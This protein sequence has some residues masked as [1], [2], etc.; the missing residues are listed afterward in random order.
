MLD[1]RVLAGLG[2][3]LAQQLIGVSL[4]VLLTPVVRLGIEY[5]ST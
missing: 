3:L 4:V 1:V 5:I 2:L